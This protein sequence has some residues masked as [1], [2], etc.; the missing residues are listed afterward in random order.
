M[1]YDC[2]LYNGESELLEIRIN[3][4]SQCDLP[5]THILIESKFTFTGKEKPHYYDNIKEQ[6]ADFPIMSIS[7]ENTIE[8]T[9]WDRERFQR[10]II[11]NAIDILCPSDDSIVIISDV[12]EIPNHK[13]VNSFDP[14]RKFAALIMKKY[15]YYLNLVESGIEWDRARIMTFG[16]LKDKS[17][18]EVRNSGFEVVYPNGGWHFGWLHDKAFTKLNSFSHAELNTP[19]SEACIN[20]RKNFWN[21][22]AMETVIIDE[23]FPEY[24]RNNID[25]FKHLIK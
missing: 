17:P 6:F 9:P 18:E 23:S 8:G 24:L 20:E 5:V 2:F 21:K 3:E 12:D 4:L 19:E 1:I 13:A 10:N 16:Y 11:M 22:N 7:V 25:K 14:K 15:G